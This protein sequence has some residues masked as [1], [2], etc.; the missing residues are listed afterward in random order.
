MSASPS[1]FLALLRRVVLRRHALPL[2]VLLWLAGGHT[3]S[4]LLGLAFHVERVA[5]ALLAPLST[6]DFPC[7]LR[8]EFGVCRRLLLRGADVSEKRLSVRLKQP[9]LTKVVVGEVYQVARVDTLTCKRRRMAL[10][11]QRPEHLRDAVVKRLAAAQPQPKTT[12]RPQIL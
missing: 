6:R 3:S 9:E 5:L 4:R 1:L 7:S 11:A 10:Q 12:Q 8:A 2:V